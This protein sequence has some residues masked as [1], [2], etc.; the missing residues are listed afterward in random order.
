[1]YASVITLQLPVGRTEEA[2]RLYEE[3]VVPTLKA[4]SGF[5]SVLVLGAGATGKGYAISTW[6]SQETAE[7]YEARFRQHAA[8]FANIL[9]GAPTRE[10]LPVILQV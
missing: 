4:A 1:M 5:K 7:A 2:M 8:N 9:V 6:E 3:R 10:L